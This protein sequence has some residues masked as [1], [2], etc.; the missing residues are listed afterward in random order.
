MIIIIIVDVEAGPRS[1]IYWSVYGRLL[2]RYHRTG[3]QYSVVKRMNITF[4][5]EFYSDFCTSLQYTIITTSYIQLHRCKNRISHYRF[6]E[7][8]IVK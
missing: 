4:V 5:R 3:N 1:P 8:E 2:Y 6:Q 7:V